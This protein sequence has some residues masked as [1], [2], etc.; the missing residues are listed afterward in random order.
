MSQDAAAPFELSDR[1]RDRLGRQL[2]PGATGG[3]AG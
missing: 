2:L 1:R 3:G